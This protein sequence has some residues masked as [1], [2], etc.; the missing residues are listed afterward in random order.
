MG[1]KNPIY[2]LGCKINTNQVCGLITIIII[3]YSYKLY[4]YSWQ[5]A[6]SLDSSPGPRALNLLCVT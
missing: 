3:I 1:F 6:G 4:M 5:H 2:I